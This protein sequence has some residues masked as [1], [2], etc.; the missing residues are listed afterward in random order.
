[1]RLTGLI[2]KEFRARRARKPLSIGG[3]DSLANSLVKNPVEVAITG[4]ATN[5]KFP[6]PGNITFTA[7]AITRTCETC[8]APVAK[9]DFISGTGTNTTVIGTANTAPFTFN[10]TN[11]PAGKYTIKAIATDSQGLSAT[12]KA[13]SVTVN[14]APTIAITWPVAG[15]SVAGLATFNITADV[16]DPD[17]NVT[18]V[19]FYRSG[20]LLGTITSPPYTV[21]WQNAAPGNYNLTARA[22]DSLG[23]V[24]T[25]AAV[26]VTV[27]NPITVA[28]TSPVNK[29]RFLPPASIDLTADA[30]DSNGTIT[31]VAYYHGTNLIGAST[32]APYNVV[33]NNVDYGNYNLTAVATDSQ[34]LTK[35]SAIVK[36]TVDTSPVV[37]VIA[38]IAGATYASPA[39]INIEAT[40][41]NPGAAITK[42]QF[43]GKGKLLGTVTSP[44]YT[45]QWTGVLKGSY[46]IT[47]KATDSLGVATTSAKVNV[48]VVDGTAPAVGITAPA[49][50][51]IYLTSPANIDLAVA[52]SSL[53]GSVTQVEFFNG[54]TSLGT[55]ITG[56]SGHTGG[57]YNLRWMNVTPGTYNLTAKATNS[58]NLTTVSDDITVKVDAAP[59]LTLTSPTANA[60]YQTGSNIPLTVNATDSDGSIARIDFYQGTTLIGTV[61][62]GTAG[63]FVF[64]WA[65]VP[66]GSYSLTATATD[67]DG[68]TTTTPPI[69]VFVNAAPTASWTAPTDGQTAMAPA[70]VM[71]TVNATDSDGSIAR[72]DFYNGTTLIATTQ[73]GQAGQSG[74]NYSANW[75]N[76]AGGTYTLN[77]IATDNNGATTSAGN[78]TIIVNTAPTISITSPTNNSQIN[79]GT[80]IA[81]SATAS[82]SDGTIGQVDFYQG[83]GASAI[84]IGSVQTGQ[85]GNSGNT[86]TFSWAN[87]VSGS[88][89]ITAVATDNQN[90][91]TTS[92]AVTVN[93]NALPTIT[94]TSP[95]NNS[96]QDAGTNIVLTA[97]AADSDGTIAK[98]EFFNGATLVGTVLAG[99]A[100]DTG[101]G[102]TFT[103]T[104]VQAG[105]YQLTAKATDSAGGSVTTAATNVTVTTVE[106]QIYYIH[107]DHLGTPRA[108]TK[109]TD[110]TKVWEWSNAEPFGNNAPNE[111]PSATG[112]N[113]KFDLR[114]PGQYFDQETGTH[115]NFFRDYDPATGR[116]VQSDPIGLSSSSL[117][118]Y[119]YTSSSPLDLVDIEGLAAKCTVAQYGLWESVAN[120]YKKND[121][122]MSLY[123][124][125]EYDWEW[126]KP[127]VDTDEGLSK[128]PGTNQPNVCAMLRVKITVFSAFITLY[129]FDLYQDFK[130][131]VLYECVNDEG[132]GKITRSFN[133]IPE[134]ESRFIEKKRYVKRERKENF[135]FE[136]KMNSPICLPN[137]FKRPLR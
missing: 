25:S 85:A 15:T 81:I 137:P 44:P 3:E 38:P 118:T 79:A 123:L 136:T 131:N 2:N 130:R 34:G 84:L 20:T 17:N 114:F 82:D 125:R 61:T 30:T 32:T 132:C 53:S 12:S 86:Y 52:A 58:L 72:V 14:T 19:Q 93:A 69:S 57:L 107:P 119:A 91:S 24:I 29:G 112:T 129:N 42:V 18:K 106:A 70:S 80:D 5:S 46:P 133:N 74:N 65:N 49:D 33:W 76:I 134:P 36:I 63:N 105:T 55:V 120:P 48:A 97:T 22:T 21:N 31:Q 88:Y 77:A 8:S 117:N 39:T 89:S 122:T 90:A 41:T 135:S 54:N 75:T 51:A 68:A 13:I 37:N 7:D 127:D 43:Y 108:I 71:L 96:T 9:V 16:N 115:Y 102:Y 59:A 116:Y 11:V 60:I 124:E 23:A 6:S 83:S 126:G 40:A 121:K 73:S 99:S 47:A 103:W 109:A 4:P 110:N 26:A 10:W 50:N 64:N 67:N 56:S 94:L 92:Q 111:D 113:F 62:S 95:A 28:I 78:V 45:F 98:V 35:T 101:S 128:R 27:T 1:M 100:G 104:N 87:V 66:A